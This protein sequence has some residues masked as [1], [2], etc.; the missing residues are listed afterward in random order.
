MKA[1]IR[2]NLEKVAEEQATA[3]FENALMKQ[4]TENTTVEIPNAMIE[5]RIDELV[6]DFDY[7]LSMQGM[8]M[9]MFMQYTG[10]NEADFRNTFRDQAENQVKGRLALIAIAKA[11][12]FVASEEEIE[13]QLKNLSE[14]YQMTVEQIKAALPVKDLKDDIICNKSLDLVRSSAVVSE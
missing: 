1:D 10:Q 6:R 12:N 3:D 4:V 7:R 5:R 8:N 11:E 14:M 2:T 9:K 13:E